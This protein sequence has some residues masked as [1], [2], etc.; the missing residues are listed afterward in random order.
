MVASGAVAALALL[1]QFFDYD[2]SQFIAPTSLPG[3]LDWL[4][5][6]PGAPPGSFQRYVTFMIS[7]GIAGVCFALLRG[8]WAWAVT[9]RA[10]VDG[11]ETA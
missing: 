10:S 11:D 6:G 5:G 4:S 7:A 9:R 1:G 2:L 8:L 3:V